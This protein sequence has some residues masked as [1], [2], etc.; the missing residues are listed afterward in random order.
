MRVLL[1]LTSAAAV[2]PTWSSVHLADAALRVG[3]PLRVFEPGDF[4]ITRAGRLVARAW[5]FEP[6]SFGVPSLAGAIAGR[7]APRRYVELAPG[8]TL[9]MRVNP[10]TAGVEQLCLMAQEH[11]VS[12]INDPAGVSR[13]RGKS[14]LATLPAAIPRPATLVTTS[15]AS[16]HAFAEQAPGPLVVKPAHGSGGRGVTLVPPRRPERLDEALVLAGIG[17]SHVVVQEYLEE[18]RD[19][20]K[21]LVWVD[22]TILGGYR[23]MRAQGDFRHNLKQGATPTACTVDGADHALAAALAPHLRRNGIRLAGLDVIGGR[24]IEVNT[25]NPGGIHWSDTLAAPGSARVAD[26]ALSTLLA[27]PSP[28]TP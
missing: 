5:C 8:D 14:W 12:V 9:F 23:R 4:E 7:A 2:D 24:I 13:T 20:E 17:P 11:G 22:G 18:A 27:P 19:G 28:P 21:R 15:R 25:L 3:L 1:L 26:A 10:F 16:A 6:P